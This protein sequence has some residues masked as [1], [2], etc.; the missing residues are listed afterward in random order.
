MGSNKYYPIDRDLGASSRTF[1]YFDLF[2]FFLPVLREVVN[3]AVECNVSRTNT[4]H[5]RQ[6]EN[7]NK[8]VRRYV[9]SEACSIN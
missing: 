8:A 1:S 4:S 5:V 2:V 6:V 9:K 7:N 3:D